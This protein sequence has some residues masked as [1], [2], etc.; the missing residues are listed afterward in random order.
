M[1][2][3]KTHAEKIKIKNEKPGEVYAPVGGN[4]LPLE[5]VEDVVFSQK[6][7]GDG[8]AVEPENGEIY[9]PIKG[10]VSVVFPTG[11]VVGI[12]TSEGANIILHVG[13]DTV[14]LKG[15]GFDVKVKQGD[16]VEAGQLL[17]KVD[18]PFVKKYHS[19]TVM[20]ILEKT[21]EFKTACV[22]KKQIRAGE[23]L[24]TLE[25]IT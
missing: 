22:G 19:A 24:L 6:I 15:K 18:L 4:V 14:E 12:T 25:R 3:F 16:Q 17:M 13:I 23:R 2:F 11:H 9:S 1:F 5:E 10:T 8:A 21:D 20:V 7:L